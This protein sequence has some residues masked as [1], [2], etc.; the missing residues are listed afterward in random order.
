MEEHDIDQAEELN[1]YSLMSYLE[2][3]SHVILLSPSLSFAIMFY[4]P[5]VIA[6]Y[7]YLKMKYEHL[8]AINAENSVRAIVFTFAAIML[9]CVLQKREL[10][11]FLKE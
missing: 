5:P 9:F 11:R 6:K 8:E 7:G 4:L 1:E 2:C 10:K 3:M